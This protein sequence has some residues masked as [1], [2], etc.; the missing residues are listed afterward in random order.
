MFYV[1]HNPP[2]HIE[3]SAHDIVFYTI[4]AR[5]ES[6]VYQFRYKHE[7]VLLNDGQ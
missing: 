6:T 1:F 5:A 4:S 7:N 3:E 2:I